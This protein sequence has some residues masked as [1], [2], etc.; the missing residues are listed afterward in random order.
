[1]DESVLRLAQRNHSTLVRALAS[2][3]QQKVAE[4]TGLSESTITVFKKDGMQRAMAI[5]A[6][7]GLKL[8]AKDAEQY[9]REEIDGL[10]VWAQKG[11]HRDRPPSPE[12][13]SSDDWKLV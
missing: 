3:T 12:P 7:A 10:F 9:T 2:V 6:A 4:L 11:M 13:S 8:V 5:A 1:M